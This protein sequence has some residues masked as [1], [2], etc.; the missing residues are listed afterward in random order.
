MVLHKDPVYSLLQGHGQQEELQGESALCEGSEIVSML[1]TQSPTKISTRK[2]KR[3]D[4]RML[5]KRKCSNL[6]MNKVQ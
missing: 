2:G 1:V 3:A 6:E 4:I 5:P